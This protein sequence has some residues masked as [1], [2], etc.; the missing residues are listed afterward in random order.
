MLHSELY[1][2]PSYEV[3]L[4]QKARARAKEMDWWVST[5]VA[6]AP[7]PEFCCTWDPSAV[8]DGDKQMA[9]ACWLPV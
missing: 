9:T 5:L 6:E 8:G 7:G 1:C 4:S 2:S 3:K